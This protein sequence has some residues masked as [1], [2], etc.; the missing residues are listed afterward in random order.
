[1]N[2]QPAYSRDGP[3]DLTDVVSRREEV[4]SDDMVLEFFTSRFGSK[5]DES[6]ELEYPQQPLAQEW[7]VDYPLLVYKHFSPEN[8]QICVVHLA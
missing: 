3:N 4:G 7:I 8:K 2:K 1:M 6:G 5:G